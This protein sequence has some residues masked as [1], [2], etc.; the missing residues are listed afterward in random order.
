MTT[1]LISKVAGLGVVEGEREEAITLLGNSVLSAALDGALAVAVRQHVNEELC[2]LATL[3]GAD[4]DLHHDLDPQEGLDEY[5]VAVDQTAV[6]STACRQQMIGANTAFVDTAERQPCLQ[7][8]INDE[9]RT[10]LPG[11]SCPARRR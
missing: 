6:K 9:P 2:V 7:A 1:R 10:E 8:M 11:H 5:E 4:F 3:G